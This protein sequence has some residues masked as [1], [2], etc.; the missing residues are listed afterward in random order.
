MR[1]YKIA[2]TP[3]GSTA[4]PIIYQSHPNGVQQPP[5]P[6][7]LNVELAL[8]GGVA[9]LPG[10]G[11]DTANYV[12][13]WGIPI[14]TISQAHN[15]NGSAITV[16]GGMGVGLPLATAESA[17]AGVLAIGTVYQAFGNWIGTNQTLDLVIVGTTNQTTQTTFPYA[18]P[19]NIVFN[20]KAG[21]PMGQAIAQTLSVAYPGYPQD[22]KVSP[23]LVLDR[24]E[25]GIYSSLQ[26][27]S[28]FVRELSQAYGSAGV[29]VSYVGNGFRVYDGSQPP[30]AKQLQ[31]IDLI[32]QP[33]WSS[34]GTLQATCVMR[35]DIQLG[36]M[37]TM[38]FQSSSGAA[39]I[40]VTT[41]QS[42]SN[43]RQGSIFSGSFKVQKVRHVGNFRQ[44]DATSWV[45]VM[46]L[47]I[48]S[49][50]FPIGQPANIV[51][52]GP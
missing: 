45:T 27:F 13:I 9:G 32:G 14:T 36:D 47:T 11:D 40:V 24:D 26:I 5:D 50:A 51:A 41:P 39:G 22:V 52:S 3:A 2:V 48:P 35:S 42:Y 37:V 20:W 38:P 49:P 30:A 15:L 10:G 18:P 29:D 21:T 31:F 1:Y 33:T 6:G 23:N 4:A 34:A 25:V 8:Y 16:S 44:P 7:A 28:Q 19:K 12:R 17:Y 43:T 46:D